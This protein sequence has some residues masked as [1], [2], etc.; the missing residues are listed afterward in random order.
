MLN[1]RGGV[2]T[3]SLNRPEVRNAMNLQMIREMSI[4]I[5]ELNKDTGIRVVVFNS[6]GEGF[7]SGADLLWMQSG[8]T[9]SEGQLEGRASSLQSFFDLS[10]MLLL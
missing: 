1:L 6:A 10:G 8:L 5:Q 4:T 2:A 3:I 7:C 9:Q